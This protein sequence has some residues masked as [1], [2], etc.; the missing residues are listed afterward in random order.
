MIELNRSNGILLT[1]GQARALFQLR[2]YH[3]CF[4]A[5]SDNGRRL[6]KEKHGVL[7]RLKGIFALILIIK[8]VI[9]VLDDFYR[10]SRWLCDLQAAKDKKEF[11]HVVHKLENEI[12]DHLRLYDLD[13][14]ERKNLSALAEYEGLILPFCTKKRAVRGREVPL[15]FEDAAEKV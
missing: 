4:R 8:L 3:Y 7:F 9:L 1:Q 15:L 14:T 2:G 11:E 12:R 10:L 13:E 5:R 6:C